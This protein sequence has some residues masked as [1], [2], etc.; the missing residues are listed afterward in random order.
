MPWPII[1]DQ[2]GAYS[3][4]RRRR[5]AKA[6]ASFFI[7]EIERES[8]H[9]EQ[10]CGGARNIIMAR[11]EALNKWCS[12]IS[13]LGIY[14]TSPEASRSQQCAGSIVTGDSIY[15]LVNIYKFADY[16]AWPCRR[17]SESNV[18]SACLLPTSATKLIAPAAWPSNAHI[19]D[20]MTD[21]D[22]RHHVAASF[23]LLASAN[24]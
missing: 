2:P 16:F 23:R 1:C 21:D 18:I 8:Y 7:S 13:S 11:S 5:L 17:L 15:L 9:L 6:I 4:R 12:C 19:G 24:S 10:Y 22:R 3:K 14:V 20:I